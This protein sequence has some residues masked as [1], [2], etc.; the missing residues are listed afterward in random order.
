MP[1]AVRIRYPLDNL[2]GITSTSIKKFNGMTAVVTCGGSGIGQALAVQLAKKGCHLAL[3]DVSCRGMQETRRKIDN[4][5]VKVTQHVAD[6]SD[7]PAMEKLA[8]EVIAEYWGQTT[9]K[10]GDPY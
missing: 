8:E 6:V 1:E 3:V 5:A 2:E 10:H 4:K 7:E 9:I